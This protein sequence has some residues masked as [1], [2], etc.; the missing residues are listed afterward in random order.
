MKKNEE[1]IQKMV[2]IEVRDRQEH[3]KG[4]EKGCHGEI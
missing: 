4:T 2:E 1:L 3:H